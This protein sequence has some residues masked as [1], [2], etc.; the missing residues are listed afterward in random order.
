MKIAFVFAP[1]THKPFSE[2]L[3]VVDEDFGVFPPVSLAYAAAIAEQAGHDVIIIDANAERLSLT[4]TIA[5]LRGF[6]PQAVGFYFSTYMFHDTLAW[7]RAIKAALG[8]TILAGGI[9]VGLYPHETMHH[10]T[11]DY[12]LIGQAPRALPAL[13]E[14]LDNGREPDL[15][16]VCWRRDGEV[17]CREPVEGLP[18]FDAYPF[19][20]RHLLSNERYFSVTSQLRNFTVMVTAMGCHQTCTFCAIAPLPF[21]VRSADSVLD[22]MQVC[23]ERFGVREIDIFDADF[24]FRRRRVEQICEGIRERGLRFEWSCRACIDSLDRD[25]L[26]LIH[27]AGCR[28]LYLGI[29]TASKDNLRR[30]NKRLSLPVHQVVAQVQR[31][32]IRPLGFFMTGV[33]GETHKSLLET[34][35]FALRLDLDYAQFSRT[36][37]KPGSALDREMTR[38]GGMD[39]WREHVLGPQLER[40]LPTPW[41]GMTDQQIERWT[42][43]AYFAFYYR[44]TFMLRAVRRV[45]S[46]EE[47]FRG[48]RTALRMVV[49][50]WKRDAE[51]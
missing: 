26:E 13:L 24:L 48:V 44:P 46:S 18:N 27:A 39:W 41:T 30:M 38:T 33:P 5:R 51:G 32:G 7:A 40:R 45:R 25:L 14:A 10:D 49:M 9:N 34:I 17:E 21:V 47:F 37:A 3:R 22:E 1:Y 12:A 31:V 50:A 19:P 8:V 36:I 20:A 11:I 16:G 4:E 2:N 6:G 28:K 15:P 35:R 23:V 43:L 42:K 29:E